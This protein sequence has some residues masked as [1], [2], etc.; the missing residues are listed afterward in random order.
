MSV[1]ISSIILA[2]GKSSRLGTDK[3]RIKLDGRSIIL[4]SIAEKLLSVTDE[5]IVVTDGRKYDNLEVKVKWVKDVYPSIGSIVGVYSG[6][7]A[8]RLNYALV[9]ACDMPLLNLDLIKHMINLPRDYD[10][11]IPKIGKYIEPL[12][13][14]YSRKCL[15]PIER[16]L[17]AGNLKLIDFFDEVIVRYLTE[18]VIDRYDSDH[19]SFFNINSPAQLR[20]VKT[21][22]NGRHQEHLH[23]EVT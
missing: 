16:A 4:Q 18:E 2:G 22:I 17:K 20:E 14:I 19:L 9:V 10:I 8:I 1:P 13:A 6:L 11:L 12:H 3:A 21:I 23:K 5:V 15:Q 7:R